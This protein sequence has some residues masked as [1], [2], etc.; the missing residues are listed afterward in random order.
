MKDIVALCKLFKRIMQIMQNYEVMFAWKQIRVEF[1]VSW[2]RFEKKNFFLKNIWK[3]FSDLLSI[4]GVE[5]S[6]ILSFIANLIL[7]LL[8]DR[9]WSPLNKTHFIPYAYFI[10]SE[11]LYDKKI[12]FSLSIFTQS[13]FLSEHLDF[14]FMPKFYYFFFKIISVHLSSHLKNSL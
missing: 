11:E 8:S 14:C 1:F 10:I 2:K 7:W 6:D 12:I 5:F 4:I 9:F 3:K 13:M